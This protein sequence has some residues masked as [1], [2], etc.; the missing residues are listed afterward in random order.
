MNTACAWVVSPHV[1]PFLLS[2]VPCAPLKR[3][4]ESVL[5]SLPPFMFER[6]LFF[7]Q[8]R[9]AGHL[10][11]GLVVCSCFRCVLPSL[12]NIYSTSLVAANLTRQKIQTA[13]NT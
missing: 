6:R 3:R 2:P 13:Q 5:M 7:V 10:F 12:Q 9:L 8:Y 4:G 11:G 1:Q